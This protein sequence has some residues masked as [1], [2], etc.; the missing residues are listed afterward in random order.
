MGDTV[1]RK[2]G[3]PAYPTDT[4]SALGAALNNPAMTFKHP[5]MTLRDYFAGQVLNG[6][7]SDGCDT[8]HLPELATVAYEMADAMLAERERA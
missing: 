7:M 5:G 1:A 2:D 3:G 6:L 8:D 4:L